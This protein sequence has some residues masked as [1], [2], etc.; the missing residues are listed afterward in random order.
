[1]GV[2]RAAVGVGVSSGAGAG[3]RVGARMGLEG[4][5]DDIGN[6]NG[7]DMGGCGRYFDVDVGVVD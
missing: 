3:V 7:I 2:G 4:D 6:G 5:W 1:M